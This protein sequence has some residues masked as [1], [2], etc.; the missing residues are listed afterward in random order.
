M[1]TLEKNITEY[2]EREFSKYFADVK[3]FRGMCKI[4][5]IEFHSLTIRYENNV[6]EI[7]SVSLSEMLYKIE[8]I[9]NLIEAIK[10][11]K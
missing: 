9:I 5:E 1:K 7:E 8:Q 2:A 4:K 3:V 11:T 6:L 10:C